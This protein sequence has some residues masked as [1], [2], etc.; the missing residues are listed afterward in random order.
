MIP[1]WIIG[2]TPDAARQILTAV[3]AA[4]ITVVG[5]VFSI[6]IVAL[7]LASTSIEG[8]SQNPMFEMSMLLP[9]T[10][11]ATKAPATGA[12]AGYPASWRDYA[13]PR[14][15][16]AARRQNPTTNPPGPTEPR[17]ESDSK[18]LALP[19]H[20]TWRVR[21]RTPETRESILGWLATLPGPVRVV[22]ETGPTGFSLIG[23]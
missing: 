11:R 19:T 3:A 6:T 13:T 18:P 4:I 10:V 17:S 16:T 20:R 23:R 12:A 7:T 15:G 5:V 14:A 8:L 2:G 21:R 22:Y 9:T 1:S